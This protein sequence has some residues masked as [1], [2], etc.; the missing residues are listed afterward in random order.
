MRRGNGWRR[1]PVGLPRDGEPLV[2]RWI[3]AGRRRA[4]RK[5]RTVGSAGAEIITLT[6]AQT[7][8]RG[9]ADPRPE[10]TRDRD[11]GGPGPARGQQGCPGDK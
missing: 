5:D 7:F 9:A 8:G 4:A 6:W 1:K 10:G 11:A 2:R 3:G